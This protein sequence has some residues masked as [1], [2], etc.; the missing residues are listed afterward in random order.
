VGEANKYLSDQ[1]PWKLRESDPDR[2]ATVLH[3]ALQLVS[4][5]GTLLSPFLPRSAELVH[6]MLG[7]TGRWQGQPE[8]REVADL[9]GGPSYLV[10]QGE[11]VDVAAR[12]ETRPL[13]VGAPLVP[14]TPLFTK[15]DASIVVEE[16]AR[17]EA[18]GDGGR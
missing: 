2:M 3:I 17:L 18:E 9:D 5:A 14:P 15:L 16:H 11:Y 6:G 8:L 13:P 7:G 1:A 4:D 10:L 12:W